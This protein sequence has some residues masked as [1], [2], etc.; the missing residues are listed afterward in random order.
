MSSEMARRLWGRELAEACLP[1][2]RAGDRRSTIVVLSGTANEAGQT[3]Q[4]GATISAERPLFE[5]GS[6]TKVFT[7]ALLLRMVNEGC[8]GLEDRLSQHLPGV[9]AANSNVSVLDLASH[10]SGLPRLPP[11]VSSLSTNP[12]AE[13][14]A[15]RLEHYLAG[16]PWRSNGQSALLY[17]NLGYSVLGMVLERAG[18][19]S[20]ASLLERYVLRRYGLTTISVATADNAADPRLMPGHGQSGFR[21]RP[22]LWLAFASCGGL[23]GTSEDVGRFASG[24]MADP[25][26]TRLFEPVAAAGAGHVG[27]AWLLQGGR[28]VAWHNGATAGFSGYL[29][30]EL[31]SQ[32]WVLALTNR[33]SPE[34]T[35][36]GRHLEN[37][38]FFGKH[39]DKQPRRKALGGLARD[40]L[41]AF[42]RIPWWLRIPFAGAVAWV[43]SWFVGWIRHGRS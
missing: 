25:S 4:W 26:M 40:S 31:R 7:A 3:W 14:T 27:L 11:D 30:L 23:L 34:L 20:F 17:S 15:E 19:E 8:L 9:V 5:L 43:L 37:A 22:W 36:V 13:Y 33:L 41:M 6:L 16:H 35:T 39:P 18:R 38:Y 24:V 2:G 29:S 12:Y 1:K 21:T 32:C 42:M 28:S 10:C